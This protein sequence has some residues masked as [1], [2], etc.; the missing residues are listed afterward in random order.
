MTRTLS[1][2]D[3]PAQGRRV[4][5]RVDF[6]VPLEGGRITDDTRLRA[7]LPTIDLLRRGGSS[8]VLA[9]HLGRPK[10]KP[11]PS[12]SLAPVATRLGELLQRPVP[13]APDCVGPEAERLARALA[14]GDLLLL[15]N[16]RFHAEEEKNDDGFAQAL[17]GLGEA[18]VDDAFGAAHRAHAS[19]AAIAR[20]LKPAAAGLLMEREIGM[21]SRLRDRPDKPYIA[22]L[23]GA[24]VSDK[25]DLIENLLPRVDAILVGGAM[26]YTFLK[27]A[28]VP[29]GGSRVEADRVEAARETV[30]R[31][32]ARGVRL[33]L[34]IDHVV[35]D[36]PQA[37]R[38]HATTDGEAIPD[39]QVG[40]DVGPKTRAAFAAEIAGARTVFWNGPLGLFEV[41]PYDQGTLAAARAIAE[42]R[43]FSVVGGGDSVA[44]VTRLGLAERFSHVSTG[45]GAS[46]E[47]L[48]GLELPGVAALDTIADRS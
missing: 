24:K 21:L 5:L 35:A 40:L 48:S 7:A 43:C 28:G 39:G 13:L 29:V 34:P 25:I 30:A 18:Y 31:A 19:V 8:I 6:N 26:A 44:A 22:L 10:G 45:G 32:R 15:E 38:P 17:A 41:P 4:F 1:V 33:L 11:T 46:L 9:S 27:A 2:R 23:G 42:A 36:G 3:L 14:Q 37:G 12:A 47:F 20:H 16:L